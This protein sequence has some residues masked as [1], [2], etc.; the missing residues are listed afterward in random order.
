M[1]WLVEQITKKHGIAIRCENDKQPKPLSDDIRVVLFQATREL[2]RNIAKHARACTGKVSLTRQNNQIRI[3][4]E[5]D[6]VGFDFAETESQV[7]SKEGG[8]GLFSIRERLKY[9]GGCLECESREG[10]GT[11]ISLIAPLKE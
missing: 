3:D 10:S 4:V 9:L 8:F 5:D 6:G 7:G 2:L 1:E 11:R